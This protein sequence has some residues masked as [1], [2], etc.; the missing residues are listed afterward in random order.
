MI[1]TGLSGKLNTRADDVSVAATA[2]PI[3]GVVARPKP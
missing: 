3:T 2:H 1:V